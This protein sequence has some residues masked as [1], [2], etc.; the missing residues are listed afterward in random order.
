IAACEQ[1]GRP[2]KVAGVGPELEDLKSRAG[3]HTEFLGF[4]PDA[5]LPKLYAGAKALLFPQEEDFGITPLEAAASGK[6]TIAFRAG[7][8]IETV[9]DGVTGVFFDEQTPAS[10]AAAIMQSEAVRFDP[11]AIYGHGQTFDRSRFLDEMG[12]LVQNEWVQHE[13]N[14]IGRQYA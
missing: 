1:L 9:V 14:M 7:G 8:A 4:V 2:L 13:Q 11:L 6:P 10:L 5:D 3:K 12:Q